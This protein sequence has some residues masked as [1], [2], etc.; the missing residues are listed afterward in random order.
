MMLHQARSHLAAQLRRRFCPGCIVFDKGNRLLRKA[1]PRGRT[2]QACTKY[3]N[4]DCSWCTS[5]MHLVLLHVSSRDLRA[6]ILFSGSLRDMLIELSSIPRKINCVTG[7]SSLSSAIGTP[8]SFHTCDVIFSAWRHS[9]ESGG[10][11][12]KKSF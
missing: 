7:P 6:T 10:P 9:V 1:F 2:W 5:R 8:S 11:S 12:I 3:P 4:N